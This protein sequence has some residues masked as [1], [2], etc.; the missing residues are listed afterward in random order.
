[1]HRQKW[2]LTDGPG[3]GITIISLLIVCWTT[4]APLNHF[5]TSGPIPH[6]GVCYS[7]V[8]TILSKYASN[9]KSIIQLVKKL[10]HI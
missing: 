3:C 10:D 7:S 4:G 2:C 9:N 6:I 5:T 1:M 8:H